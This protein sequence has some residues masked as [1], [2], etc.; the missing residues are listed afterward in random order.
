MP[1][2]GL[3]VKTGETAFDLD[4]QISLINPPDAKFGIAQLGIQ[5]LMRVDAPHGPAVQTRPFAT[6]VMEP[7]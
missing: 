4:F 2:S 3:L 5:N 6:W 7:T 1:V